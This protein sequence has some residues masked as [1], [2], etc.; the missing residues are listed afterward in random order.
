M[1]INTLMVM[2]M[3]KTIPAMTKNSGA[4]H[5]KNYGALT[6]EMGRMSHSKEQLS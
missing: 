5:S 3:T 1:M 2:A 4:V 6:T